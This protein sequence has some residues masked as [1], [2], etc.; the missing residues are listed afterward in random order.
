MTPGKCPQCASYGEPLYD[1]LPDRFFDSP[2]AWSFERCPSCRLIWLHPLP[3]TEET[4]NLP[5]DYFTH[6]PAGDRPTGKEPQGG[7]REAILASQYGYAHLP[8]SRATRLL[9]RLIG[10]LPWFEDW[11]GRYILWLPW[12]SCGRLLEI[13]SGNGE[14]LKRMQDLGWH[15]LGI[16]PDEAAAAIARD[17]YGVRVI[18]GSLDEA[19]LEDGSFQAIVMN[20]VLEHVPDPFRALQDCRRLLVPGGCLIIVTPNPAGL[21]H[22]LFNK[23]WANLDPPRHLHLF[24]PKALRSAV[25]QAG[26]E[27]IHAA[28]KTRYHFAAWTWTASLRIRRRGRFD[29]RM[30]SRP[31]PKGGLLFYLIEEA[32]RPF[33]KDIG[34]EYFL[35]AVKR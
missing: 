10:A 29:S 18:A 31:L 9:G 22:R 12:T 33:W 15:G 34:E 20:H 3:T 8:L 16:E 13:G 35:L 5:E 28:S 11:A 23:S 32:L 26:F 27:S 25:G 6:R 2:G 19:G 21:G 4:R 1:R 17:R 14:Y 24:H 30:P 7:L